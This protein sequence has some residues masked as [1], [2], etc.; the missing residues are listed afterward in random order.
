MLVISLCRSSFSKGRPSRR[1]ADKNKYAAAPNHVSR[2]VLRGTLASPMLRKLMWTGLYASSRQR[3]RWPPAR[4]LQDLARGDRRR[5]AGQ[6]MTK[7]DQL[8]D[9]A[10]TR[11]QELAEQGGRRRRRHGEVRAAAGRRR[12]IPPQAQAEPDQGPRE[13]RGADE[14]K[15]A[16]ARSPPQGLSSG[17]GRSPSAKV[18]RARSSSSALP[19]PPGS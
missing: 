3:R 7:G 9:K 11:L 18:G 19:L 5:A 12:R 4:R 10:A 17:S 13:G 2:R 1:I 14:P 8:V 16:T 15:P 6:E